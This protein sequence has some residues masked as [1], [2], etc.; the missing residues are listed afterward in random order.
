[1]QT[2]TA[3][4]KV[5]GVPKEPDGKLASWK[6]GAYDEVKEETGKRGCV[7]AA[8][9]RVHDHPLFMDSWF[10]K[11][12]RNRSSEGIKKRYLHDYETRQAKNLFKAKIVLM[13]SSVSPEAHPTKVHLGR[14]TAKSTATWHLGCHRRGRHDVP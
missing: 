2:L 14:C 3:A 13:K 1:M 10:A 4:R 11:V 5:D 12:N 9:T 8:D 6:K 7:Q